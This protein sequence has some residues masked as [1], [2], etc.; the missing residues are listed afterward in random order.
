MDIKLGTAWIWVSVFIQVQESHI[1]SQALY[2]QGQFD[3]LYS[4]VLVLV[5]LPM[6][7]RGLKICYAVGQKGLVS[8]FV[9]LFQLLVKQD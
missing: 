3:E 8:T 5:I 9:I 2:Y 1:L 6:G 4:L 7:W